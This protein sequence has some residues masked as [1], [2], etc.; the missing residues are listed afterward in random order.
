[1]GGAQLKWITVDRP[2]GL[3]I[4]LQEVFKIPKKCFL[5]LCG[6]RGQPVCI[7]CDGV[8]QKISGH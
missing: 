4:S 1:M 8:W 6:R 7:E 5:S 3:E 2:S